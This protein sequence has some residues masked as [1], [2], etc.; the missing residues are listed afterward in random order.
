VA[1]IADG[2]NP[3]TPTSSGRRP[4]RLRRQRGLQ[5]DWHQRADRWRRGIH[6]LKLDRRAGREVYNLNSFGSGL[7]ASCRIRILGVAPGASLVGLNVFG[8]AAV[9]YDSVFL[10]ASTTRS[11]TTT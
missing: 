3:T 4:A 2:V 9:A 1:Y 7:S 8:S 11:P 10:E 6:R 5:R